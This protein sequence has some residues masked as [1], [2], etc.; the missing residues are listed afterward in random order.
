MSPFGFPSREQ[1]RRQKAPSALRLA[2]KLWAHKHRVSRARL[3]DFRV[4]RFSTHPPLTLLLGHRLSH[5][6]KCF[7]VGQGFMLMPISEIKLRAAVFI[8]SVDLSQIHA[9]DSK[10][11][12]SNVEF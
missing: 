11:L 5:D 6:A 7:S 10:R 3:A 4:R 9:A 1:M 8:D 12:F 2:S